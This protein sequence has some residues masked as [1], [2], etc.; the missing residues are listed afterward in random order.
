MGIDSRKESGLRS[1]SRDSSRRFVL[2]L[3][4]TSGLGVDY[5]CE[6]CVTGTWEVYVIW[7][8]ENWNYCSQHVP[9]KFSNTYGLFKPG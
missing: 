7:E 2:D 6:T 1:S 9:Y 4:G 5:G 8:L 3:G